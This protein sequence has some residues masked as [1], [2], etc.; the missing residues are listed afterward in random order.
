MNDGTSQPSRVR[1]MDAAE[2][3]DLLQLNLDYIRKLSREGTI[4]AHRIPGGR[5]FRYFEDEI[6][7]WLR[8]QSA[9][10]GET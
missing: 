1:V 3:A 9:H 2:V 8:R 4:P 10:P 7:D 5:T 6:L